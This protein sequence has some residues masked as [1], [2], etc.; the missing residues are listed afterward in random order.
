MN[1][2]CF[3]QQH[4]NQKWPQTR[5]Q[6]QPLHLILWH[7]L[8]PKWV[9]KIPIHIAFQSALLNSSWIN[10]C[11]ILLSIIFPTTSIIHTFQIFKVIM[12]VGWNFTRHFGAFFM[13]PN[14]NES[15]QETFKH[16][17]GKNFQHIPKFHT[18]PNYDMKLLKWL[19][20]KIFHS[21]SNFH[22]G[23]IN[24]FLKHSSI[25]L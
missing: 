1:S 17:H 24:I 6:V 8:S 25:P 7:H 16:Q 20:E 21:N 3:G 19:M 2:N 11:L 4:S 15:I 5:C 12:V 9:K 23:L 18:R 22:F 14:Q 13:S 10:K